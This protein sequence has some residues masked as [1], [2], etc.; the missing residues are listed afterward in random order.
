MKHDWTM[1][2]KTMATFLDPDKR[3]C[4]H[5]GVEQEL[6]IEQQWM[7]VVSRRWLPLVGR[8]KGKKK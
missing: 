2:R 5:C 8:C 4:R 6:H 3:K 1:I 7:R